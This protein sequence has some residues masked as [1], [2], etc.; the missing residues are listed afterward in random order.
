MLSAASACVSCNSTNHLCYAP[1]TVR[2]QSD[3][4]THTLQVPERSEGKTKGFYLLFT[5]LKRVMYSCCV[6]TTVCV[7]TVLTVHGIETA[8]R[9]R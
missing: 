1:Q 9:I 4:E 6:N 5:V 7:A 8:F 3:D 2:E